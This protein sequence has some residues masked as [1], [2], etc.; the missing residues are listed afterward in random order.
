MNRKLII[1]SHRFVPLGANLAQFGDES[2]VPAP[3][4]NK[5]TIAIDAN[6]DLPHTLDAQ[7]TS[8]RTILASNMKINIRQGIALSFLSRVTS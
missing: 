4:I 7:T 5:F 8:A 1:K 6:N 3:E 2:E